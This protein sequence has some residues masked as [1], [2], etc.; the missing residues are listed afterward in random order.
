[1]RSLPV[2]LVVVH[3]GVKPGQSTAVPIGGHQGSSAPRP[4]YHRAVAARKSGARKKSRAKRDTKLHN[5]TRLGLAPYLT[6]SEVRELKAR[7]AADLRSISNYVS[8]LVVEELKRKGRTR[9]PA[10]VKP[11]EKR[12]PYAI[13]MYLTATERRRLE[14]AVRAERRSVSG[15]VARVIAAELARS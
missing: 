2:W 12:K 13:V 15:L 5:L 6:T 14:A 8:F 11:G 1:M 9:S 7:A 4:A 10:G 3:P